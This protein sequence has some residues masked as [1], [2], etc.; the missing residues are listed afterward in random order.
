[1][2]RVARAPRKIVN[3][4]WAGFVSGPTVLPALT[5]TLLGSFIL[6]TPFEETAVRV[7]GEIFISSD[8]AAA[9]EPQI[10]AFGLI[11]VTDLALAAGI[12]SIP[13]P[14]V[15]ADD[16]GWFVWQGF[17]Q[18][19]ALTT[20]AG[21]G[22]GQSYSIDSKAQRIV[23]EGQVIAVVVDNASVT[24]GAKIMTSFRLLARFRG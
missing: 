2:A 6:S 15:D 4:T 21:L 19:S 11:R 5:K 7:R 3:Y 8:Q 16:D 22:G 20:T 23:R 24:T 12:G 10:G 13:S 9:V 14:S 1:M 18:E 17:A